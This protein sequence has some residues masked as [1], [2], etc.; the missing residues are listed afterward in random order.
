MTVRHAACSLLYCYDA[1]NPTEGAIRIQIL[2]S[3]TPLRVLSI[4]GQGTVCQCLIFTDG[5]Q[6]RENLAGLQ[7]S[8]DGRPFP[9]ACCQGEKRALKL[10]ETFNLFKF[11]SNR[12]F[13]SLQITQTAIS[14]EPGN[15]L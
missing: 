8:T 13:L 7:K 2:V 12:N 11:K 15:P 3:I 5:Q 9:K 10:R 6:N 4:L 14:L 1:D